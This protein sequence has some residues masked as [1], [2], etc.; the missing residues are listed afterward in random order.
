MTRK[1]L[2]ARGIIIIFSIISG[3]ILGFLIKSNVDVYI[4]MTSK[5]II[6]AQEDLNMLEGEIK[7]LE[8]IY[9]DRNR[10]L[11]KLE[12]QINPARDIEREILEELSFRKTKSG[13][14]P[15]EGPGI[16]IKMYDNQDTEIVGYNVNDDIIHDVDILNI[17]NDLRL[18]GAEAISINGERILASSEIK[19]GGPI[20]KV[21]NRSLATPF[22][23]KVVGDKRTLMAAVLAPGTYGDT[24]KNVYSIGFEPEEREN[25]VIPAYKKEVNFRYARP[26]G[27]ADN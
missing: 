16:E 13:Y 10:Q 5:S 24:L 22:I 15:V 27:E 12:D 4:P 26:K 11:K 3:I 21:N 23:I 7:E 1:N 25:I 8:L 19:C 2:K 14:T 18:A 6:E 9:K 20:I 17:L